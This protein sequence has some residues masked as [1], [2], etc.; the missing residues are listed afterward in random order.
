MLYIVA[1][2][3]D[4]FKMFMKFVPEIQIFNKMRKAWLPTGW[5]NPME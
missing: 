3:V 5:V 4:F 2:K 1:E